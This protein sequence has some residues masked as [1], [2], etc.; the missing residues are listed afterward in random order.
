MG[1]I[2]IATAIRKSSGVWEGGGGEPTDGDRLPGRAASTVGALQN[3][4][5]DSA[6]PNDLRDGCGAIWRTTS[7]LRLL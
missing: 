4:A 1:V 6:L 5:G 3:G 7:A 2:W